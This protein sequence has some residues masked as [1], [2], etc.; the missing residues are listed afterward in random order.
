MTV[1]ELAAIFRR[2]RAKFAKKFPVVAEAQLELRTGRCSMARHCRRRDI[3]FTERDNRLVV[4]RTHVLDLPKHNV[5]G[6]IRHELGHMSDVYISHTGAEQRAD[7]LAEA[8]TG[9]RVRYDRQ[10]LQTT[11]PGVYPRPRSLPR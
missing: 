6:I 8:A 9:A 3:A 11:G 4:M 10:M 5:I 1:T 2:E 7:D